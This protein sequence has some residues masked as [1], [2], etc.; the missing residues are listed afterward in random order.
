MSAAGLVIQ[1]DSSRKYMKTTL[2]VFDEADSGYAPQP[3]MFT[4]AAQVAHV[5]GTVEWFMEGAFGE[6]WDMD[7]ETH[8]KHAR[9]VTSL[10]E[11]VAQLDRVTDAAIE[12]VEGLSDAE[13]W[14]PI[15]DQAIMAGAPRAAVVYG[16]LDHSAHHR[17]ALTVY[18]RLLGKQP[19]MPY[20]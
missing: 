18:A 4:V 10:A 15:A 14:A 6:G 9:E 12:T 2:S 19:V 17:G 13:L 11:A 16:I 7:F 1:L 8:E 3:E 20:S 5:A